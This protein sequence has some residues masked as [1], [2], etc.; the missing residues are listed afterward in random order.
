[1]ERFEHFGR[2]QP[3]L[4]DVALLPELGNLFRG[5]PELVCARWIEIR[6]GWARRVGRF[7]LGTER[8]FGVRW[9]GGGYRPRHLVL[10]HA[11]PCGADSG[12]DSVATSR[13]CDQWALARRPCGQVFCSASVSAVFVGATAEMSAGSLG[14]Y[15]PGADAE[16]V[17]E[18]GPDGA[19]VLVLTGR[20]LSEPVVQHGPFVINTQDEVLAAVRD[21]QAGRLIA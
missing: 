3:A 19:A 15:P 2:N 13:L 17:L 6:G 20:P 9:L 16:L 11:V 4:D 8:G 18:A 5:E 1:M 14:L 12:R 7:G 21:Y 10:G